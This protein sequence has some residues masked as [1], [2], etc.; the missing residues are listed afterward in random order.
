MQNSRPYAYWRSDKP[1]QK[2]YSQELISADYELVKD[3]TSLDDL[4]VYPEPGL[5]TILKAFELNVGRFPDHEFLGTRVG[6]EYQWL[7][8]AQVKKTAL[9]FA[10]G[11]VKLGLVSRT[12]VDG[13][14][15]RFLGI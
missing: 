4:V 14:T 12:S 3:K 5:D 2:G 10:A 15:W 11:C 6:D 13:R 8:L 9:N 1:K 7:T